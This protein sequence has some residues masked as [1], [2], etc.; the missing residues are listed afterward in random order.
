[1]ADR[2]KA[3]PGRR[4]RLAQL[5]TVLAAMAVAGHLYGL[6]RPSGPPS[7]SWFPLSD[8]V[9][10]LLGFAAPVC[11]ILLAAGYRGGDTRRARRPVVLVVVAAFGAHAVLSELIQHYFYT[12]RT[13]DPYD[14]AA[15]WVGVGVGWGV[16]QLVAG[17]T[18][19]VPA[20]SHPPVGMS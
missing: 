1:M 20:G 3:E 14:V 11:L 8:K 6:Y 10:H 13:G 19:A 4:V 16:A 9:G 17:G 15:D 12:A 5:I 7:P 2:H 18:P